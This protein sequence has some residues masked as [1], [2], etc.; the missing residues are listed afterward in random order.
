M[1]NHVARLGRALNTSPVTLPPQS[2][3]PSI[4]LLSMDGRRPP[5][6]FIVNMDYENS[7]CTEA[8]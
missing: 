6:A 8:L 4:A 1:H 3:T 2:L 7:E 5:Y